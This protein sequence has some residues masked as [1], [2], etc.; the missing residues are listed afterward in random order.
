MN[1]RR[2]YYGVILFTKKTKTKFFVLKTIG[3]IFNN[4]LFYK[5]LFNHGGNLNHGVFTCQEDGLYKF[6]AYA[7]TKTNAKLFLEVLKNNDVVASLWG[8]T[9]G[10]YA[11]AGN[12]VVLQLSAGDVVKV[13]TRASHEMALYGQQGQIYTT[14]SGVQLDSPNTSTSITYLKNENATLDE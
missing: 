10:D 8:H 11:S 9:P 7:L 2:D 5:T 6:Q 4:F 14:F 1:N 12:A 3:V 13:V